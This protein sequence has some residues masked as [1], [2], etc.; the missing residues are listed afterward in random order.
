MHNPPAPS[1]GACVIELCICV[2]RWYGIII[3]VLI[4]PDGFSYVCTLTLEQSQYME[5]CFAK[6]DH[7]EIDQCGCITCFW[8]QLGL[9]QSTRWGRAAFARQTTSFTDGIIIGQ[10]PSGTGVTG[11]RPCAVRSLSLVEASMLL[12]SCSSGWLVN[13]RVR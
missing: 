4:C 2:Y 10:N 9:N 6:L 7:S 5:E 13:V 11:Q 8:F 12:K 3:N 1:A